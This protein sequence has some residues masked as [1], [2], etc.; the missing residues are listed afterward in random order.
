VRLA[1]CPRVPKFPRFA[2]EHRAARP[3][4]PRRIRYAARKC[5]YLDFRDLHA[6][7][8]RDCAHL[9]DFEASLASPRHRLVLPS[10]RSGQTPARSARPVGP[11]LRHA[12][13][14]PRCAGVLR[15]RLTAFCEAESLQLLAASEFVGSATPVGSLQSPLGPNACEVGSP[16]WPLHSARAK[17]PAVCPVVWRARLAAFRC[18]E[19]LDLTRW[20]R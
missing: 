16:C 1:V 3:R 8:Y 10:R 5:R 15:S 17:G 19:S 7:D 18:R 20:L 4:L 6:L 14:D 11:P 13:R 2:T 9:A 12:Q